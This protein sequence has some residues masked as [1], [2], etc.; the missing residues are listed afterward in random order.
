MLQVEFESTISVFERTKT[1][2][3]LDNAATVIG[4]D[5]IVDNELIF[6]IFIATGYELHGWGLIPGKCR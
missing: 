3:A 4:H 2:R 6:H 1:V 5:F